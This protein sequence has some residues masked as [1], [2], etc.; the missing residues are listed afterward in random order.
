VS[1]CGTTLCSGTVGV[2]RG[3]GV[4]FDGDVVTMGMVGVTTLQPQEMGKLE[5]P[6][7]LEVESSSLVDS[8]RMAC[9]DGDPL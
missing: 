5:L 8:S 3:T 6:A 4:P 7:S 1:S 2:V 9:S